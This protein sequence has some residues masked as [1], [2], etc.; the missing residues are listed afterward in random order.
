ML[1]WFST[2]CIPQHL[3]LPISSSSLALP[4]SLAQYQKQYFFFSAFAQFARRRWPKIPKS[5][6]ILTLPLHNSFFCSVMLLLL[7]W[8]YGSVGQWVYCLQGWVI[9]WTWLT[10][11]FCSNFF[12]CFISHHYYSCVWADT[13]I[14]KG[15]DV[16]AFGTSI[17]AQRS[18]FSPE[19][20]P[21]P[22]FQLPLAIAH[23]RLLHLL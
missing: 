16:K 22:R 9:G 2:V 11:W 15:P 5:I 3:F 10:I 19:K 23:G 13:P 21:M 18:F 12:R 1:P 14:S 4:H 17:S 7:E 8:V 6:M 20:V